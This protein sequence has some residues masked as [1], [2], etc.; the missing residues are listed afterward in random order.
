MSL[1]LHVRPPR[2]PF[3]LKG[4]TLSLVMSGLIHN[5]KA[6]AL[7]G[8]KGCM[9]PST[10]KEKETPQ[11]YKSQ[12]ILIMK[13]FSFHVVVLVF[14]ALSSLTSVAQMIPVTNTMRTPYGNVNTTRWVAG[15]RMYN[16]GGEMTK[17]GKYKLEITFPDDSVVTLSARF[18][19]DRD[20]IYIVAKDKFNN[21]LEIYPHQTMKIRN[22]SSKFVHV[23]GITTD[24]SWLFRVIKGPINGYSVVPSET[25]HV[26]FAQHGNDGLI[27]PLT[28][29]NLKPL[30]MDDKK[31]LRCLKKGLLKMAI[32]TFNKNQ[33]KMPE[34]EVE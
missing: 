20:T 14:L 32:Q 25:S 16:G 23:D 9:W 17:S 34:K 10:K 21:K 27:F 19:F 13:L 7:Q 15:P 18:Y 28:K 2:T 12:S 29:D 31:A 22:S 8:M 6:M 3:P 1:T 33:E 24:S 4:T 26:S 30:I 11:D 5:Y